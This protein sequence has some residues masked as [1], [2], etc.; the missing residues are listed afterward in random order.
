MRSSAFASRDSNPRARAIDACTD[1]LGLG[2]S[3]ESQHNDLLEVLEDRYS[4]AS[5]VVTSQ[6]EQTKWHE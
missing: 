2:T 1:H 3:T 6:L 4:N 5:T